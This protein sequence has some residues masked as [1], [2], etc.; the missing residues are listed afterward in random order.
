MHLQGRALPVLLPK[1]VAR[2]EDYEYVDGELVAGL[3]LGWNFGD[4]HLHTEQLLRA[5]GAS[6][7]SIQITLNEKGD[8]LD[9]HTETSLGSAAS[10][11]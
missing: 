2:V 9:F 11:R 1:A 5:E 6:G 8:A 4:G 7:V 3:A 10:R